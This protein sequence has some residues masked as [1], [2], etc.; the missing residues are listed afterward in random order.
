MSHFSDLSK[1]KQKKNNAC[2]THV[3]VRCS[4]MDKP[5]NTHFPTEE[6]NGSEKH[7][8]T[9]TQFRYYNKRLKQMAHM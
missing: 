5:E 6:K 8:H 1:C 2:A 4:N 7:T 9:L 3:L